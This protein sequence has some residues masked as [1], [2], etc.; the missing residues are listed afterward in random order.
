MGGFERNNKIV[1][2][3]WTKLKKI[4][5]SNISKPFYIAQLGLYTKLES[6]LL[7]Y[8]LIMTDFRSL[9]YGVDKK[10]KLLKNEKKRNY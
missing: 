5:F 3:S 6:I 9:R 1:F 10:E 7:Y 4:I 8:F 2:H